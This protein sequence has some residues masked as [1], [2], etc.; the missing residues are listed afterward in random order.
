MECSQPPASGLP[1]DYAVKCIHHRMDPPNEAW[2]SAVRR[3]WIWL[4]CWVAFLLVI[5]STAPAEKRS[6]EN[7]VGVLAGQ[8]LLIGIGIYVAR[9][10][11][12]GERTL[13]AHLLMWVQIVGWSVV[14][15]AV[16]TTWGINHPRPWLLFA[17]AGSFVLVTFLVW[18]GLY[19][20]HRAVVGDTEK[21]A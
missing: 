3:Y 21:L 18:L 9:G 11:A 17:L 13:G 20:P 7:V 8:G 15:L 14:P 19:R 1:K 2:T 5:V 4:G 16:G 10:L 6:I 12:H